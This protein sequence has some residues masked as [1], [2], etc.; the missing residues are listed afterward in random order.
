MLFWSGAFGFGIAGRPTIDEW[1]DP[2]YWENPVTEETSTG[3]T[4]EL[5]SAADQLYSSYS[6]VEAAAWSNIDDP[7]N[8]WEDDPI[9]T[10]EGEERLQVAFVLAS[11][12]AKPHFGDFLNA[13]KA[14]PNL[15]WNYEPAWLEAKMQQNPDQLLFVQFQLLDRYATDPEA[16][17]ALNTL[18]PA[19]PSD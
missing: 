2:Y 12:H 3:A 8:F 6:G 5:K 13:L 16:F 17:V 11:I 19:G 1:F 18:R 4:E 14:D 7:L 15:F 10:L 9:T